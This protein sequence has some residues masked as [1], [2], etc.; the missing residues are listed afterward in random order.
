MVDLRSPYP[1]LRPFQE[2]DADYFFG[3]KSQIDEILEKL[4]SNRFITVI[5]GSGSGKSF[6]V[7]AGA[8]PRLRTSSLRRD[9]SLRESGNFWVSVISTPGT[10]HVEGDNPIRRLARK[11]CSILSDPQDAD[12][13]GRLEH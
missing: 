3:R 10:N 8:I 12:N 2:E 5:G 13:E 1:G 7:L 6:L 9:S 4:K 11:F